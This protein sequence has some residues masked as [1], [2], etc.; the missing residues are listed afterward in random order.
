MRCHVNVG[1]G[2][3]GKNLNKFVV[4][5]MHKKNDAIQ[6]VNSLRVYEIWVIYIRLE[7]G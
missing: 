3:E 7:W 6:K 2:F 5:N 1:L 4:V